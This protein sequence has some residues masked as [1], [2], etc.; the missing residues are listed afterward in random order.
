MGTYVKKSLNSLFWLM[1]KVDKKYYLKLYPRYLKWLGI[2]IDSESV[3]GTWISPTTF[4]D[5]SKYN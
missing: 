5:S 1:D 4:F 2:Q 3:A